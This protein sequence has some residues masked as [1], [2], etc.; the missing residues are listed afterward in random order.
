MSTPLLPA[1]CFECTGWDQKTGG[2]FGYCGATGKR[3]KRDHQCDAPLPAG[4]PPID[5]YQRRRWAATT[6]GV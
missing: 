1:T 5:E 4:I 3:T 6:K 2:G